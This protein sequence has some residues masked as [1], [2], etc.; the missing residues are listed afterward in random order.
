MSENIY[1][2]DGLRQLFEGLEPAALPDGFNRRLEAKIAATVAAKVRK[3]E[4]MGEI[5]AISLAVLL[6][7]AGAFFVMLKYDFTPFARTGATGEFIEQS[8]VQSL[9][10]PLG[11]QDAPSVLNF[12]MPPLPDFTSVEFPAGTSSAVIGV[13][14]VMILLLGFDHLMRKTYYKR[15]RERMQ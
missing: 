12:E 11:Q 14:C 10:Q 13:V 4:R 7:L 6:I 5:L 15:H 9:K 1:D 2:D 3:R 8:V